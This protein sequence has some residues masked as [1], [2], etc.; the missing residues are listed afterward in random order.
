MSALRIVLVRN[1][2]SY[3]FGG[4]ERFPIFLAKELQKL[5]HF[6][7]ILSRHKKLC[8]YAKHENIPHYRSWWWSK[9]NWSGKNVL[10]VPFYILW[11]LLL[12]IYY[13]IQF[14][15]FKADVVHL[16][17]KDD[18]IA[19]SIAGKLV[20][21]K[22]IWTDHAD[23]KHVW[24]NL[25]IKYK[26]PTGKLVAWSARFADT[27]TAVSKSEQTLISNNLPANSP[28]LNKIIVIY[29]GVEDQKQKYE[30][31]KNTVF[32]FCISGRLVIDKGIGE[33]ITAFKEFNATYKNSQLVL[34][35]DGP[36]RLQFEQQAKG[37]PVT[38]YGY[39]TNPLPYVASAD[40]YLH[41]TYH[42]GFS[43]SLIEASMLGLPIIATN[44]GGNPEIIHN[45]KTGLLIPSKNASA[46]RD[47]MKKLYENDE[48]RTSLS[49]A[50]RQQYLDLFVFHNI[51]KTQFIP[52][53][54]NGIL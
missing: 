1:A 7:I 20:G 39:K 8:D 23:L 35:G 11:Q 13:A 5:G 16:Q 3:D 24:K 26:N 46:L 6:P 14:R 51:V 47:S 4:G 49:T 27:I 18:F 42:E 30:S 33:A 28:I 34:I 41:P 12:T 38:F 22:V 2:A 53:Y 44:V 25:C 29:N 19:G 43:V 37:L 40:I 54:E 48:L 52:I 10:L 45:N 21:A 15:R 9:Q 36:D 17:S 31:P 32:T 50:A